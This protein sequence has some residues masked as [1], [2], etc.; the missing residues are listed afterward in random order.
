MRQQR[1]EALREPRDQCAPV[2]VVEMPKPQGGPRPRGMA[3]GQDRVVQT[4]MTRVLEPSCEAD[5]HDCASGYRPTRD[6]QHASMAIRAALDTRAWGVVES[7]CQAD[8][9][10]IPHRK[11]RRLITQRIADGSLLQ[12]IKQTLTV[13]AD[14]TGQVRPTQVG[15]PQG[16]P[17]SPLSSNIALHLVDQRWQ[18]RGSPAQRGATLHRY[19]D[20]ASLVCRSR[21]QPVPAAFEAIATR[22]ALTLNRDKTRV[23]RV[24]EGGDFLGFH[25]VQR[26]SPRSGK[27][28]PSPCSQPRP[29]HRP[30]GTACSMSRRDERRVTRRSAWRWCIR[31]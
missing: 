25:C 23:T 11:L 4:A 13:G 5:V 12:L 27:S 30:C 3:T 28:R 24:T 2:R 26:T 9:T 19:A 16:S 29:P 20:D 1:H 14:V 7:D 17:I 8:C 22:M 31:W 15:V 10:S 18:S 6:A 21:P